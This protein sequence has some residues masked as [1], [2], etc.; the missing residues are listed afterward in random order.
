LV[1]WRYSVTRQE[2]FDKYREMQ[3]QNPVD[4][5]KE[6]MP[7]QAGLLKMIHASA[8]PNAVTEAGKTSEGVDKNM[9]ARATDVKVALGEVVASLLDPLKEKLTDA[10]GTFADWITKNSETLK[11]LAPLLTIF[12]PFAT[13]YWTH[14]RATLR[15]RSCRSCT[16]LLANDRRLNCF[17]VDSRSC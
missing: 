10:L 12:E 15:R 6:N 9:A 17:L 13:A 5:L 1:F 2:G 14:F 7:N 4:W 3:Q 16:S 8:N 11:G